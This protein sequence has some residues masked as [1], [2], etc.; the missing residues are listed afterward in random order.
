MKNSDQ[1][2][3]LFRVKRNMFVFETPEFFAAIDPDVAMVSDYAKILVVIA[4]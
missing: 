4:S 2:S 3:G 1:R